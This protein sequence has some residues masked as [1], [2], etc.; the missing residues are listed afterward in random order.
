MVKFKKTLQG[1]VIPMTYKSFNAED[2]KAIAKKIATT[3]KPGDVYCLNGDLGAGKTHFAKGF[4]EGLGIEQTIL[5]P[6]FTILNIYK[7]RLPLYHFDVFRLKGAEEMYDIGFEDYFFD[8]GVCLIEWSDIVEEM[9][10]K[11]S[12]NVNITKSDENDDLRIIE[13][14][15]EN[16]RN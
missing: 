1:V 8:D 2:T 6:T 14:V 7:G 11:N 13:V 12:I 16:S 4:A 15:Y 5:S 3:A 10:P 9:L